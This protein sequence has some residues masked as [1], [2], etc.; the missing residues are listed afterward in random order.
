MLKGLFGD[1]V[2]PILY[3]LIVEYIYSGLC[4]VSDLYD[5][6]IREELDFE[7]EGSPLAL[8]K[9][10]TEGESQTPPVQVWFCVCY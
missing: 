1:T 3:I 2:T 7:V 9:T 4:D 6:D 10:C 5:H 8:L